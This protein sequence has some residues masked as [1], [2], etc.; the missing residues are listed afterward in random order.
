MVIER[1]Q[2]Y[3]CNLDPV[4]GHEQGLT[5]PVV[6]V[7][8]DSYNSS[9]SPLIAVIPLTKAPAKNPIHLRLAPEDTGLDAPSTALIDHSRFL[10]RTRLKGAPVGRL[11]PAA[12]LLLNR[13][14]SRVLG[15]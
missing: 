5:R 8:S 9:Q 13:H 15:L 1:G 11:R 3:W 6:I 14:L 10:D 2:V 12:M 7:S 4:H